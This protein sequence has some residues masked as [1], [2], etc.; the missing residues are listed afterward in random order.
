MM[1]TKIEYQ[2]NKLE[3]KM[4]RIQAVRNNFFSDLKQVNVC[5]K[6]QPSIIKSALTIENLTQL[7]QK[8]T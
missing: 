7:Y 1:E 6:F 5:K 8:K 3:E 4:I 2:A